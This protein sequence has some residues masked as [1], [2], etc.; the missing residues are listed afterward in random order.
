[1]DIELVKFFFTLQNS[2]RMY[3]WQTNTYSRH[4]ATDTLLTGLNLLIDRFMEVFQGRYGKVS[5]SGEMA[6]GF[7]TLT[8]RT[9][10]EMI[11]ESIAFLKG[12]ETSQKGTKLKGDPELLNI[13][14]EIVSSLQQTLYLFTFK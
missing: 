13:R 11:K 7:L 6:C 12:L 9:A 10:P 1:M 8:D 3:H 5:F 14:D 4:I 2:I